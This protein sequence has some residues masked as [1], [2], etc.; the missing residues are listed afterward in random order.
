M[1]L[2]LRAIIKQLKNQPEPEKFLLDVIQAEIKTICGISVDDMS[3]NSFQQQLL[4]KGSGTM[5]G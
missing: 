3:W 4:K 1:R 5:R 2:R